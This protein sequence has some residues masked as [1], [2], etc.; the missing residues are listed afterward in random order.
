MVRSGQLTTPTKLT[1]E[2]AF[3][4]STLLVLAGKKQL[5]TWCISALVIAKSA[6]LLLTT[7]SCAERTLI[8]LITVRRETAGSRSEVNLAMS[9][10]VMDQFSGVSIT[11]TM[12]G[13][14]NSDLLRSQPKKAGPRSTN[15][16]DPPR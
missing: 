11:D 16:K 15:L 4:I 10:L 1:T 9:L 3:Q 12:F 7:R 8:P 5:P 6:V 2:P 14:N 13:S